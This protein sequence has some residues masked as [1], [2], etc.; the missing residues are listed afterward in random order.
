MVDVLTRWKNEQKAWLGSIAVWQTGNT[1]VVSN[2][3]GSFLDPNN[4]GRWFRQWCVD[5][6]FGEYEG[7]EET[8]I[9]SQGRK[10]TR[11]RNYKG[12]TPHM[13]RHTQ[14]TLLLA[15][16]TDLKTV[17]SRLGHSDSS[18][19]LGVYSHAVVSKDEEAANTIGDLISG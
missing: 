15:E 18:L 6:G 16:N 3:H 13:L 7:K 10:R 9:D 2:E 19:T 8:Y 14:A 5:N 17:Q 12:L 1:P 11:K 4:Y